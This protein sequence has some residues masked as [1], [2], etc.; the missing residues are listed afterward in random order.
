L[1]ELK[2]PS[3]ALTAL[4]QTRGTASPRGLA[5]ICS[6]HPLVIEVTLAAARADDHAVLIE[7]TCNQVNQDGGY[8]GMTPA[9]FVC[10]VHDHATRLGLSVD[11]IILGGDHLGPNPWR[12]LGAEAALGKAAVMVAAYAAAG[13]TKIHLD[14]S[15]RCADDP[16]VLSEHVIASRAATLAVVAEKAAIRAGHFAPRYVVGTEVPVPGGEP[17]RLAAIAP[18]NPGRARETIVAHREAFAEHGIADAAER[19]IALVVQPGVEFSNTDVALYDSS[20]AI[21][22][23]TVL[24]EYPALVFEAHSTDYQPCNHL[25]KMVRDGFAIL[26]VGPELT[27]ALRAA[28]YALDEIA[29]II[30]DERGL[31]RQTMERLMVSLPQHW[32]DY[33]HGGKNTQKMLR[34]YGYSDRIR[35][36]WTAPSAIA[37]VEKLLV[38]LADRDI[39]KSLIAQ[40]LPALH[41]RVLSGQIAARGRNLVIASISDVL[42]RY[43][44]ATS[45]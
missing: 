34:H 24:A 10:F 8:S 15:M 42:A 26:K 30:D 45:G 33:C 41:D 13:F 23:S 29:A 25:L 11:R 39:P 31:L 14:T 17:E 28:L 27:F 3:D 16:L 20:K 44:L 32:Q 6:A 36:Y 9:A 35:Y 38:G 43:R 4:A 7:A 2:H 18:T 37:A 1:P 12:G 5:S 22:L 21:E 19:I 40:F